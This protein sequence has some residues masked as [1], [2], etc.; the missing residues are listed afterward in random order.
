MQTEIEAKFVDIDAD[1]LRERLQVLGATLVYPERLMRRKNFDYPDI[2]KI[3]GWVRVR[4]EGDK[5]TL[6]YKQV[7]DHGLHGTKEI[8]VVVNDFEKT[9]AIMET[10]GM[11]TKSYQETKREKWMLGEVEVTIDTWP[12]IPTFAEIEGPTEESVKAAAAQLG[13]DWSRAM[14]GSVEPVYTL[15]Y[16]VPAAEVTRWASITFTPVPNWLLAKKK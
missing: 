10:I 8:S 16:D 2:E 14:H 12:W 3:H 4:D 5:V 9:C 15:H 13:Q 11:N 6:S 7:N 1:K